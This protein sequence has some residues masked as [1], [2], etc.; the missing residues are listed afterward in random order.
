MLFY[1][2]TMLY[3]LLLLYSNQVNKYIKVL[4]QEDRNKT[5]K[6]EKKKRKKKN[7]YPFVQAY[8]ISSK[9]FKL[10]KFKKTKLIK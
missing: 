7:K 2:S 6:T 4:V 10:N 3:Y 9:Q 1:Y 8:T 5:L